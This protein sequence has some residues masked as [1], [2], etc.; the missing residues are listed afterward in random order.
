MSQLI[1]LTGPDGT[2]KSTLLAKVNQELPGLTLASIWD[3]LRNLHGLTK[4]DLQIYLRTLSP[5]ARTY[6]LLHALEEACAQALENSAPILF[7][8]YLYKYYVTQKLMGDHDGAEDF[9]RLRKPDLVFYLPVEAEISLQRK[10]QAGI[11]DY[12]SG[13]NNEKE[14]EF[15]KM[16]KLADPLWQELAKRHSD[17]ITL[18]DNLSPDEKTQKIVLH[19]QK[20]LR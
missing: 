13:F 10:K 17:W 5:R 7:D 19:L 1:V 14:Q 3:P 8:G 4:D 11:S 6:F 16:Q 9:F 18:P 15:L 2:G 12:E 20:I